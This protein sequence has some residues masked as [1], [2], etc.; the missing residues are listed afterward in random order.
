MYQ[1]RRANISGL[2][3]L[4][5]SA[6]VVVAVLI[7]FVLRSL[8]PRAAESLPTKTPTTQVAIPATAAAVQATPQNRFFIF[9][10]SI[11]MSAMI[12]PVYFSDTEDN[13]DVSTLGEFAGHLEGTPEMGRGGN[14]VLAGHIELGDGKPGPF[15]NI[16]QLKV[17]DIIILQHPGNA[18]PPVQYVV[19]EVKTVAPDDFDV[20]RNHGYEELTLITC[21]DW[22]AATGVYNNRTVVH[23]RPADVAQSG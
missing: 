16:D 13:W 5:G 8:P 23:A 2:S 6:I 20:L 15:Y 1:R 18:L 3:I 14:F 9:A 21:R 22:D 12:V 10:N 17:G 4:I 11:N 7:F 19:T